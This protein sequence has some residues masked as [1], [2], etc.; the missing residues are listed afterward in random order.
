MPVAFDS[1]DLTLGSDGATSTLTTN[2]NENHAGGRHLAIAFLNG[3]MDPINGPVPDAIDADPLT[4]W[5]GV[6]LQ[7]PRQPMPVRPRRRCVPWA[8]TAATPMPAGRWRWRSSHALPATAAA[9]LTKSH[10]H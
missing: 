9:R 3:R 10:R 2:G 1:K 5:R 7:G 6:L 4:T 8:A